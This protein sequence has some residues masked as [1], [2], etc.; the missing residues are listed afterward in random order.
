MPRAALT[1]VPSARVLPLAA[2][3]SH[4]VELCSRPGVRA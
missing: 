2:I 3:A 1:A 4:L